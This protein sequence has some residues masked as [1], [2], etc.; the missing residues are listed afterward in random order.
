MEIKHSVLFFYF[1]AATKV[2]SQ[3]HSE[4]TL[5]PYSHMTYHTK[6]ILFSEQCVPQSTCGKYQDDL[7]RLGLLVIMSIEINI[8]KLPSVLINEKCRASYN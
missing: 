6:N 7:E 1:I 3:C 5:T 4:G 8:D 2:E